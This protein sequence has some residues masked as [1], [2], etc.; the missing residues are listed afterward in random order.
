MNGTFDYKKPNDNQVK[1]MDR[2]RKAAEALEECIEVA[3]APSRERSL[4][5]TKLEEAVMWANKAVSR[6]GAE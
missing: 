4:A 5:A 6:H 1:A 3:T 2:I